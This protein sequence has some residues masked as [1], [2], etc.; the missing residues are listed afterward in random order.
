M[1][2][3][4]KEDLRHLVLEITA[5]RY[6]V[7]LTASAIRRR[8]E[9]ELDFPITDADIEAMLEFLRG[10]ALCRF[11]TDDFGATRYWHATSA[12]VLAHERGK[13]PEQ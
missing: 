2:T 1:I 9:T 11:E 10:L 4:E 5:L 3:K 13:L 6:P 12:G 8:A 7:A